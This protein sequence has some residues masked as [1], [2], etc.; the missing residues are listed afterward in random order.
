MA[1]STV[2]AD[3]VGPSGSEQPGAFGAPETREPLTDAQIDA[4]ARELLAQLSLEE[5]IDMMS[6]GHRF[7]PGMLH[8]GSAGYKRHPLTT[9]GAIP[10]LGIPGLRFTDGSRGVMLAGA[11]TFP[12]ASARGASWDPHLEERIGDVMG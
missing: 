1:P 2:N 9:V 3:A 8:V 11:T 4:I 7:F 12:A 6:G 5:K 10:R